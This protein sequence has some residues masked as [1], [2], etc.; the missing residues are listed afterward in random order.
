MDENL[1][2]PNQC[3]ICF[4]DINLENNWKC[5]NC[6]VNIHPECI[7]KWNKNKCPHCQQ[8]TIDLYLTNPILKKNIHNNL[9]SKILYSI[10]WIILIF[11][12]FGGISI[13]LMFFYMSIFGGPN[14]SFNITN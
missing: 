6:K 1:L 9:Y 3:L 14:R 10:C 4:E 2:E 8:N 13:G 11:A 5:S 7:V 12:M